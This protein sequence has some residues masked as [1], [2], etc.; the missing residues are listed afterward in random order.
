MGDQR[1]ADSSVKD[2]DTQQGRPRV[3]LFVTCLI[4]LFRPAVAFAAVQL[5]E[6]A[7]CDVEVPESQTCCGQPALNS[8][9]I[10]STRL[11]ARQTIEAFEH[12]DYVVGASG[13]CLGTIRIHYPELFQDDKAWS[14]RAEKM[15]ARSYELVTFLTEVMG[16]DSLSGKFQGV[17]TYHDSCSGLRELG[18]KSQPRTLLESLKGVEISEMQDSEVCCGFGGTFCVKYP[19]ISTHL[20]DRKID[21]IVASEA[22]ILTG[23]DLGCLMNLGGR[24]KRLCKTTRVFHV[25]EILAGKADG[26]AIAEGGRGDE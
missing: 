16:V 3:G 7:G 25:A 12:F 6:E 18:I 22:D 8:G 5:L 26:P 4:D 23:G 19:E 9:D 15:A 14:A 20:A 2:F 11:I 24:L 13:S 1:E 10:D 17:V 21:N